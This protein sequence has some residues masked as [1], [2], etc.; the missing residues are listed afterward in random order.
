[1]NV[2][3][4]WYARSSSVDGQSPQPGQVTLTRQVDVPAGGKASLTFKLKIMN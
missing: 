1:M 2:R 4:Q 3:E